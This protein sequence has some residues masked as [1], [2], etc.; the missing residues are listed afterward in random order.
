MHEEYGLLP[1]QGEITKTIKV[2]SRFNPGLGCSPVIF[3][4]LLHCASFFFYCSFLVLF[5]FPDKCTNWKRL[6]VFNNSV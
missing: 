3:T 5:Y 6:S 4:Q 1:H 2:A